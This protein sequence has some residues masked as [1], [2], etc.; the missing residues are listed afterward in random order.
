MNYSEQ[1]LFLKIKHNDIKAFDSL[2]KSYYAGLHRF[3]VDILKNSEAAEEI[4]QDTFVKLWFKRSELV[5]KSSLKAYMYKMIYNRCLNYIRDH[6]TPNKHISLED[7]QLRIELLNLKSDDEIF[8]KLLTDEME[9]ELT[10]AI[11]KLPSQC[12]EVFKLCRFEGFT[13]I[14]TA[15]KLNISVSTVKTQ[16]SRAIEKLKPVLDKYTN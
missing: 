9:K 16:V 8:E 2:F 12:R 14:E 7:I 11:G 3:A 10:E 15:D 1:E 5:I 4:V 13:Y 6:F